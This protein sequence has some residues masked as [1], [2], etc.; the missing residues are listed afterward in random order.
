MESL[1]YLELDLQKEFA[2]G[3]QGK[4]VAVHKDPR[5]SATLLLE[6]ITDAQLKKTKYTLHIK[7]WAVK[8]LL[9][10]GEGNGDNHSRNKLSLP[11]AFTC[12]HGFVNLDENDNSYDVQMSLNSTSSLIMINLGFNVFCKCSTLRCQK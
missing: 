10:A 9:V 3:I 8:D 5:S 2:S 4:I 6:K 7:L 11:L 12:S 1:K